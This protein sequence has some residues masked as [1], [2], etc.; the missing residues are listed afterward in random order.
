MRFGRVV[1]ALWLAVGAAG[2][3][4]A[5]GRWMVPA[6]AW[7]ATTCL[8]LF[9]R[10]ATVPVGGGLILVA[11]FLSHLLVWQGLLPLPAPLYQIVGLISALFFTAP[12]VVDRLLFRR[13]PA[14]VR[15]LVYPSASVVFAYAYAAV[16]P[17]G[18]FGS[19][20]YSQTSTLVLQ[21]VSL[22][23]IWG[24]LF[25]I[26]WVAA[27]VAD[28]I[29]SIGVG[30]VRTVRRPTAV[31][32]LTILALLAYGHVRLSSAPASGSSVRVAAIVQEL[33]FQG[34]ISGNLAA[35]R[36]ASAAHADRLL[37]LSRL[38]AGRG[39]RVILW[40]EAAEVVLREDEGALVDRARLLARGRHVYLGLSLF[41]VSERFPQEPAENK[42]LW[43]TPEGKVGPS[44]LKAF[45]TPA[46][47]VVRGR[48]TA[49]VLDADF[50]RLSSA[51]CFDLNFPAFVRE[52]GRAH[53]DLL[54]VPANDWREITPYHAR[55]ARF[56]A[57]ENGFPVVRA[58][59][60]G[61]SVVYD[62]E[63]REGASLDSFVN[64]EPLLVADVFAGRRPTLYRFLGD[65]LPALCLVGLLLGSAMVLAR[66][67]RHLARRGL[68]RI[69]EELIPTSQRS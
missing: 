48:A 3:L 63:G 5:N 26:G 31:C 55:I 64:P 57:I 54:A 23:G 36:R 65:V 8:L 16:S 18:T 10:R 56:R 59:G 37:E 33:T 4:F 42:I 29:E 53:V 24:I 34:P 25:V 21:V 51:I 38:A 32:L 39:A 35:F 2:L 50:G 69:E 44:Y 47:N 1:T 6:A 27:T 20:A 66:R 49:S 9:C 61:L 40:Q 58:T 22:A 41:T 14:S 28:L 17:S 43:V 67:Q 45:P 19:L 68:L 46:E 62:A 60:H 12:F 30:E 11:A 15:S 52:I 13:L 7:V